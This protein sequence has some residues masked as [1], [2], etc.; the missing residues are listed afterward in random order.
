MAGLP[1][2]LLPSSTA[3]LENNATEQ[4]GKVFAACREK[5]ERGEEVVEGLEGW[6]LAE[7]VLFEAYRA[8]H[9]ESSL[10]QLA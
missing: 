7:R 4:R 8:E 9:A 6:T 5:I 10:L 2:P 3:P 1:E